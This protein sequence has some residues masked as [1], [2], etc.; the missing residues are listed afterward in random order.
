MGFQTQQAL[1]D[2]LR[3]NGN[4]QSVLG[5]HGHNPFVVSLSNHECGLG[6]PLRRAQSER[7]FR[8]PCKAGDYAV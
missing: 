5:A 4:S 7:K 6:V 1:F 8:S 3:T 2:K